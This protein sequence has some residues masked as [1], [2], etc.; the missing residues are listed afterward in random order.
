MIKVL[1][2]TFSNLEQGQAIASTQR[3]L[4]K[5]DLSDKVIGW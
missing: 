5:E 4:W 2:K 1:A 3:L